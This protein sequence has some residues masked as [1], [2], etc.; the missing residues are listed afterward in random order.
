M[1]DYK[2]P[3]PG[4]YEVRISKALR[5][6]IDK[7][8]AELVP[9]LGIPVSDIKDIIS[10]NVR[11]YVNDGNLPP[12]YSLHTKLHPRFGEI[13]LSTAMGV[14][15]AYCILEETYEIMIVGIGFGG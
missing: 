8:L 9:R 13:V 5:P 15:V 10:E 4:Y 3:K 6:K 7:K 1:A 12:D 2:L 11:S 14:Q